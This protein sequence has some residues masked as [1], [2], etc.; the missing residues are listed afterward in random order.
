MATQLNVC[1]EAILVRCMKSNLEKNPSQSHYCLL[2]SQL[3]SSLF[4]VTKK[5]FPVSSLPLGHVMRV[6]DEGDAESLET[7]KH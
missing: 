3:E 4:L 2:S 1:G 6:C 7:L 5:R